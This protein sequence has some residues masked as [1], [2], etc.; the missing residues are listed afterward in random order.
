MIKMIKRFTINDWLLI[1][2]ALVFITGGVF[3]DISI[4]QHLGNITN[5]VNGQ[6]AGTVSDV[7]REGGMMMAFTIGSVLCTVVV[8]YCGAKVSTA[9]AKTLRKDIYEQVGDFAVTDVKRFSI[10]SLIT[11]ATNDID[12]VRMFMALAIIMLIRVPILIIW[13]LFRIQSVQIEMI[14]IMVVA[15]AAIL[16][17]VLFL[18]LVALPRFKKIRENTDKLNLVARENL[19]GMRVVRAYNAEEFHG[20]KYNKVNK[21]LAKDGLFVNS[22]MGLLSPYITLVFSGMSVALFWVVSFLIHNGSVPLAESGIFFGETMMFMQYS[23]QIL[24]AVMMLI[25]ILTMLPQTVVAVKRINEVLDTKPMIK[26]RTNK[27]VGLKEMFNQEGTI[28]YEN[29]EFMYPGANDYV[30]KDINLEIKRGSSVAFIGSTGCGK[31]SLINLI[32]KIAFPSNGK[33][34]IGG[35][36]LKEVM[37]EEINDLVGYVSQTATLFTGTIKENVN[38]G[39]VG[40]QGISDESI[41]KA[42]KTAQALEFVDSLE[43]GLDAKVEQRGKNFSGGQKQRL[44]IARILARN[45]EI[46]LFDD[47]FSALDYKTDLALREAIKQ[48]YSDITTLI[49]AQRIGTIRNCDC[50]YVM[51]KGRIVGQGKHEDLIKNCNVYQEIAK[52][53]LSEAEMLKEVA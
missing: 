37:L 27:Y 5:I 26:D 13:T 48:E 7:W 47:T 29:V 24:G 23:F 1:L 33:V 50:I 3:M 45:P 16:V 17:L 12:I 34:Y 6:V 46:I 10:A 52:S 32:P 42:L 36:D 28:K 4:P 39:L 53:Q 51:D 21:D 31:S 15:L 22:V 35:Q 11:R 30:L 20:K 38:F 18:V 19:T 49:V 25:M 8:S 41:Q 43:E 2:L 14:M 40:G 44:S 9:H